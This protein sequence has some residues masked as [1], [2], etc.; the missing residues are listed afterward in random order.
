MFKKLMAYIFHIKIV[1]HYLR[2]YGLRKTLKAFYY[3]N[4]R[5]LKLRS[6]DKNEEKII[7]V[8]GYKMSVIPDD[9]GISSELRI[10]NVHE[11]ITTHITLQELKKDM[12][13]LDIGSNIGYSL[14]PQ[15]H[16]NQMNIF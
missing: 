7:T 11:P 8:N 3:Y 4:Y 12:I 9:P 13:C 2:Y 15:I 16:Y 6:L 10:F 5:L 14:Y 1:S